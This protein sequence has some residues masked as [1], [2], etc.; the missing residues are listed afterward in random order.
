MDSIYTI[1]THWS[2]YMVILF[3]HFNIYEKKK[4]EQRRTTPPCFSFANIWNERQQILSH[5]FGKFARNEFAFSYPSL[6]LMCTKT[7]CH[8]GYCCLLL[9][10]SMPDASHNEAS[11]NKHQPILARKHSKLT[12]FCV[13]SDIYNTRAG[14][15]NHMHFNFIESP[16]S[17]FFRS[18]LSKQFNQFT[19][20]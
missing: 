20:N 16:L 3:T 9:L 19:S 11:K 8:G 13:D 4:S 10:R 1:C 5:D 6:Q 15:P 17:L 12:Y 18:T 7:E 14:E 2:K